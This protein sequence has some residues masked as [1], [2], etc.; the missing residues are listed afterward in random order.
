MTVCISKN[1]RIG[2][3]GVFG[4]PLFI[5]ALFFTVL[6]AH[7]RNDLLHLVLYIC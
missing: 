3:T 7:F 2:L 6:Y 5:I 1:D 4:K